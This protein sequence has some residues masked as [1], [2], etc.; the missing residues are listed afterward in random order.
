MS[1]L[2][3]LLPYAPA[4]PLHVGYWQCVPRLLLAMHDFLLRPWN[5]PDRARDALLALGFPYSFMGSMQTALHAEASLS[6]IRVLN[7]LGKAQN[8]SGRD[9]ACHSSSCS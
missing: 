1:G 4:T 7:T 3:P 2:R 5:S 8:L 9:P 6:P